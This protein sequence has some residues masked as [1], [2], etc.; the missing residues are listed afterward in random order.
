MCVITTLVVG[1]YDMSNFLVSWAIIGYIKFI[2]VITH[3]YHHKRKRKRKRLSA[4]NQR[5]SVN[6]G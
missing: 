2:I 5:V 3:L 4:N 6:N 1:K